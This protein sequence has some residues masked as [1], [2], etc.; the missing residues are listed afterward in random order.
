MKV[1]VG[2]KGSPPQI[3]N[4]RNFVNMEKDVIFIA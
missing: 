3:I 2:I 1:G 4:M